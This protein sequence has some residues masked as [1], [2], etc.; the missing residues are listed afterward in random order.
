[1]NRN[2]D[3]IWLAISEFTKD[4]RFAIISVNKQVQLF[5]RTIQNITSN[6]INHEAI[7]YEDRF[8]HG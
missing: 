1:M 7:S 2:A 6:Y 4:N 3:Q 5:T 8:Y